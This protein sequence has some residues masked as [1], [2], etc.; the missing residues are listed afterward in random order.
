MIAGFLGLRGHY[1]WHYSSMA[2]I[3]ISIVICNMGIS[4]GRQ[5]KSPCLSNQ[6]MR[7][8]HFPKTNMGHLDLPSVP[9]NE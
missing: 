3:L 7:N 4:Y 1:S 8:G 5:E 2:G 6:D 9:N